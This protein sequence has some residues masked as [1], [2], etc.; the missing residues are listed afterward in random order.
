[1]F[2]DLKVDNQGIKMELLNWEIL[3][4]FT[5]PPYESNP[6]ELRSTLISRRIHNHINFL[7]L[8]VGHKRIEEQLKV[9]K[10]QKVIQRF[11][12]KIV[13]DI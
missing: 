5:Y 12:E 2:Q 10:T 4:Q 7:V 6:N 11:K 9:K 3:F 13:K 1:M 8:E